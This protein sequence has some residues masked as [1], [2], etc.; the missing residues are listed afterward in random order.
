MIQ[1]LLGDGL[2][3]FTRRLS[4]HEGRAAERFFAFRRRTSSTSP[5]NR[6]A[7]S[8]TKTRR[9]P[10]TPGYMLPRSRTRRGRK[11]EKIMERWV[12][13]RMKRI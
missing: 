6:P 8:L 7:D 11:T 9:I 4:L 5:A 1:H 10:G 12:M 2:F 13:W 3:L